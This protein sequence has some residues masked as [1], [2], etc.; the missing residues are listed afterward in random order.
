MSVSN[1]ETTGSVAAESVAHATESGVLR[2]WPAIA[3]LALMA[4]VKVF[5]GI[6]ESPPLAILMVGFVG[7]GALS[8]LLPVWWLFASRAKVWEKVIGFF[9][10]LAIA[11]ATVAAADASMKS[12]NSGMYQVP[13]GLACFGLFA[14]VFAARPSSRVVAALLGA[15]I[16]FGVWDL[17]QS[18]GTTGRFSPELSWRWSPTPEEV[19]LQ[20]LA[21]SSTD[22][23]SKSGAAESVVSASIEGEALEPI[24]RADAEWPDFRGVNR[25]GVVND[26]ALIGNW[27]ASPPKLIW[28]SLIGPGWSSFSVAGNRLFTQEQR[29]DKEAV[30]CLDAETGDH[31]WSHEYPGRFWESIGGAGPRATPTIGDNQLYTLGA[32]GQLCALR[33]QTGRVIWERNLKSDA[34]REP[35]QWGWSSSPLLIGSLVV[36]HAGGAGDKGVL[37]YDAI[38]GEAAWSV[39]SG[40]HSYSSPQV[41][42][43]SGVQGILMMTNVG[44]QF[45]DPVDGTLHWEHE[46]S[47]DNYRA[48]QPLVVGDSVFI[49]TSLGMGTRRITA[50]QTAAA[51]GDTKTW[52]VT[53]DWTSL[54]IKP[55]FNDYVLYEGHLYGFDGNI[56]ACVD[57]STGKRLWKKGRYGNGQVILL[58]K[59]GQLL[60]TTETGEIVL[61][62]AVPKQLV[63]MGKFDAIEGKTWNHSVLVGNRL[64]VRNGQEAACFEL[65]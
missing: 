17:L 11:V 63:E 4:G 45:L 39:A 24:L 26:V 14:V 3:I 37:A 12:M 31:L 49:A 65:L 46:W 44:L 35:P 22:S 13:F 59:N 62:Q 2:T 36:V 38:T 9:G 61:V 25:D 20:S 34:G 30:V 42:T 52:N 51:E 64:Y 53:E 10:L 41:A 15:L 27:Q 19:Y 7:P 58:S 18:H 55:D 16:G 54:E 43:L 40:D 32:D 6:F 48:V 21:S 28:K 23:S 57:A 29:G 8:L 33:P 47:S 5:P 56:F 50:T 60:V 1:S